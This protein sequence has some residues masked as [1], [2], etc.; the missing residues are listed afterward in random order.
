MM[1]SSGS[2]ANAATFSG[3]VTLAGSTTLGVANS[4]TISG[5]VSG[6]GSSL[7]LAGPGTLNVTGASSYKFPKPSTRAD[8]EKMALI[9]GAGMHILHRWQ[10]GEVMLT[11]YGY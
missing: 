7:T 10:A 2:S 6:A 4:A 8:K 5:V 9:T 3:P 11:L 1:A